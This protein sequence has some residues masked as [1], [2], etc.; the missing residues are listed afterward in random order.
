MNGQ[1]NASGGLRI[2]PNFQHCHKCG[3]EFG[4]NYCYVLCIT[5]CTTG[6]S[7]TKLTS[8]PEAS[9]QQQQKAMSQ[10]GSVYKEVMEL[11][12]NTA[13]EPTQTQGID[14]KANEPIHPC[15]ID[16]LLLY[17]CRASVKSVYQGPQ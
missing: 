8:K 5:V 4:V 15:H 14:M 13:Y 9:F 11:R 3:T 10:T 6:C 17:N 12:Q 16:L 1:S 2:I 7:L